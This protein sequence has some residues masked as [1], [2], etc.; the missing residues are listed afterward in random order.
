MWLNCKK[1]IHHKV[2]DL[3]QERIVAFRNKMCYNWKI[4]AV[5]SA[6]RYA[7]QQLRAQS[8]SYLGPAA[9]VFVFSTLFSPM[10]SKEF[11]NRSTDF[12][13]QAPTAL[14]STPKPAEP[15]VLA[16]IVEPT[17]PA[18][19]NIRQNIL[20]VAEREYAKRPVEYDRTVLQ[21]TEGLREE[22]CADFVSYVYREAG[23]ALSNPYSG[24]WRIPAVTSL[25]LYFASN[26]RYRAA[27]SYTPRPGDVAIYGGRHTNIVVAVDG[28]TM[29]TIGGNENN[30]IMR[31]SI[32]Y[33]AGSDGLTGFGLPLE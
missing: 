22:W 13:F 25:R 12:A 5:E 16:A 6:Q 10:I 21:Y 20:D 27:G 30:T 3:I 15:E 26:D 8:K 11:A 2:F 17:A 28:N 7:G 1:L 4:M 24:S 31:M 23:Q 19:Q 33:R 29:T 14:V 18:P 32:P 9:F